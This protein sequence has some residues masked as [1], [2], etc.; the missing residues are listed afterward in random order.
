V[1][2]SQKLEEGKMKKI[3][4]IMMACLMV[5]STFALYAPHALAEK[6]S[7]VATVDFAPD[8]INL[9]TTGG[10]INGY[11][12]LPE[13]YNV[14]DIAVSK[15]LLNDT[16][17]AE[18]HPTSIG[19]YDN[20]TFPDLMV[21]FNRTKIIEYILFN[22]VT[23]GS[24]NLT[25]TGQTKIASFKGSDTINVSSLVGDID[26]DGDVDV[27]DAVAMFSIYGSREGEPA[28]NPNAD[29]IAPYG[30]INIYDC[31]ALVYHYGE[32]YP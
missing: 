28:W 12:E 2:A 13:E 8:R 27:N 14:S 6:V 11:I 3:I 31:V 26:C 20:D 24:V 1:T 29:V 32:K 23:Y 16:I 19:D 4:W 10:W 15:I 30:I 17:P 22:G 21:T 7:V 5:L 25:L 18:L 9:N